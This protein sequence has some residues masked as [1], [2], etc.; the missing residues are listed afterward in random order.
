MKYSFGFSR[1]YQTR[2][3]RCADNGFLE[4]CISA[5]GEKTT[6]SRE[7]KTVAVVCVGKEDG[8]AGK[9]EGQE[10]TNKVRRQFSFVICFPRLSFNEHFHPDPRCEH[11]HGRGH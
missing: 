3:S 11:N 7:C 4:E 1:P 5:G 2:Y 6:E 10:K 8:G 9:T